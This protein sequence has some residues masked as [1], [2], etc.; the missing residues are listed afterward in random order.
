MQFKS[1]IDFF[2]GI[3]L[4]ISLQQ[5]KDEKSREFMNQYIFQKNDKYN[6]D[7]FTKCNNK[8]ISGK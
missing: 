4:Q 7:I 5:M 8:T 1:Y 3:P 6:V 2:Q